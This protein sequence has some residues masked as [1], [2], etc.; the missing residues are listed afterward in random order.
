VREG[1]W[2]KRKCD[3]DRR[4]I[5]GG[6]GGRRVGKGKSRRNEIENGGLVKWEM[7]KGG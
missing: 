5:K 7:E 6:R 2:G 1:E 4:W 3:K